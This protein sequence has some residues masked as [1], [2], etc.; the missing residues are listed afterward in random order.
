M[1]FRSIY[2]LNVIV[3]CLLT[4][5][6]WLAVN[7]IDYCFSFSDS[8]L[9]SSQGLDSFPSCPG[10]PLF[11]S[12]WCACRQSTHSCS[13]LLRAVCPFLYPWIEKVRLCIRKCSNACEYDV[14]CIHTSLLTL[15]CSM[16]SHNLLRGY[17]IG[18]TSEP[19]LFS[20][21]LKFNPKDR[22]SR[23]CIKRYIV[24]FCFVSFSVFFVDCCSVRN[25]IEF[26]ASSC[27]S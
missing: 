24:V 7:N 22:D 12:L 27:C 4:K 8:C 16:H 5:S 26:E 11:C 9:C 25:W 10:K 17:G 14:L 1:N 15:S 19:E 13:S 20:W 6:M 2:S 3:A 18:Q 21:L 23:Q